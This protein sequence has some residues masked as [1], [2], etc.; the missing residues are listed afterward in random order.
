[1]AY[2]RLVRLALC[3]G[4][5]HACFVQ[6]SDVPQQTTGFTRFLRQIVVATIPQKVSKREIGVTASIATVG[7]LGFLGYHYYK[8]APTT[9]EALKDVTD[10]V[11]RVALEE[12]NLQK[13]K[14][15]MGKDARFIDVKIS[16][17]KKTILTEEPFTPSF[18]GSSSIIITS[19]KPERPIDTTTA[20]SLAQAIVE[21]AKNEGK[22]LENS[23]LF[24]MEKRSVCQT[25]NHYT[26]K[27]TWQGDENGIN[28]ITQTIVGKT[29]H[30][31]IG[32][33]Q[34]FGPDSDFVKAVNT[35]HMLQQ[36]QPYSW[37][38]TRWQTDSD[39]KPIE[40][41]AEQQK[42]L[43]SPKAYTQ[44]MLLAAE[45]EKRS[46]QRNESILSKILGIFKKTPYT[47]ALENSHFWL[48]QK[49]KCTQIDSITARLQRSSH[50]YAYDDSLTKRKALE[51][52]AA[53][54]EHEACKERSIQ[55]PSIHFYGVPDTSEQ[56]KWQ[57]RETA[58]KTKLQEILKN[59]RIPEESIL[60]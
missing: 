55:A 5:L 1:M 49:N 17:N 28:Q 37:Q 10:A 7:F 19:I 38:K 33:P 6:A 41:T 57:E 4:L 14:A 11:N 31:I 51:I 18:V 22:S 54:K 50:V 56:K 3:F 58:A 34:E 15:N 53:A 20:A 23:F 25:D 45:N 35:Y 43:K 59:M 8:P 42:A 44:E 52:F 9:N 39:G 24:P 60:T 48:S 26:H 13:I 16:P 46:L 32:E 2:N 40:W 27:Y 21:T 29:N 47:K 12:E 36:S 30:L